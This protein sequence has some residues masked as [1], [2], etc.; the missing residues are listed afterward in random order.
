MH[1]KTKKTRQQIQKMKTSTRCI[2]TVLI[3]AATVLTSSAFAQSWQTVDDYQYS[4]GHDAA[5]TGLC[6]APN[7]TLFAAGFGYDP[8]AGC[9]ALVMASADGGTTWSAPLDDFT[10]AY[11]ASYNAITCDA[12][13]NLYAAGSY[14]GYDYGNYVC[15]VRRSTDGGVTW[16]T[17]DDYS[18][19]YTNT[20]ADAVAADA[21]GNVYVAGFDGGHSIVRKGV[22]GTNFVTVDSIPCYNGHYGASAPTAP[23]ATHDFIFL[24]PWRWTAQAIF[25]WRTQIIARSAK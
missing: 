6:I 15:L 2:A 3:G 19:G 9:H 4:P 18:G 17:V 5:N 13:G 12:A 25:M 10:S 23:G 22:G 1:M 16:S 24:S 14:E 8:T 11:G 7:G 21:A 20:H